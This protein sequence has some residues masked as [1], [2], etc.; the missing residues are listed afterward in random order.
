M[1]LKAKGKRVKVFSDYPN[2]K[3]QL[4]NLVSCILIPGSNS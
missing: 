4:S 2:M 3:S 1:R